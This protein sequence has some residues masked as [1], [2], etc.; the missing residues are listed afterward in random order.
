MECFE[1]PISLEEVKKV[2]WGFEGEKAPR[3]D[4]FSMEF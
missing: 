1:R 2:I 4:G 3:P